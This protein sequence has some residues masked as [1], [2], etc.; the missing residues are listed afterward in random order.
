MNKSIDPEARAGH[1]MKRQKN[2]PIMSLAT[3]QNCSEQHGQSNEKHQ[4]VQTEP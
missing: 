1:A 3:N 2:K 4:D